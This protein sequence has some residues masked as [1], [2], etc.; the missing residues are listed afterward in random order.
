MG[1]LGEFAG[2]GGMCDRAR[3]VV[4]LQRSLYIYLS[5]ALKRNY[6]PN[7]SDDNKTT[8]HLYGLTADDFKQIL[9]IVSD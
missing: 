2:I 7:L 8:L 9:N 5:R 1:K 4:A 6:V 3:Y